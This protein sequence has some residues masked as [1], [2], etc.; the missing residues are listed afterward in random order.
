MQSQGQVKAFVIIA[1]QISVFPASLN[2]RRVFE[3]WKTI[4]E[5]VLM[6]PIIMILEDSPRICDTIYGQKFVD[7]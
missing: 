2:A 5:G 1:K 7:I 6:W 3:A 4:L